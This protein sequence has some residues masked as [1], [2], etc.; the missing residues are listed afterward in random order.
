MHILLTQMT[1][2]LNTDQLQRDVSDFTERVAFSIG[3]DSVK[4]CKYSNYSVQLRFVFR[5]FEKY[6]SGLVKVRKNSVKPV[7]KTPVR[8]RFDSLIL[9]F[10]D[11]TKTCEIL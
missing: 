7:Y 3:S 1:I 4:V 9:L 8:V 6:G 10:T 2:I 11:Y 5:D